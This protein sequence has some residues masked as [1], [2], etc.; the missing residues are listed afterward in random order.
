MKARE[1]FTAGQK[2]QLSAEIRKLVALTNER[3]ERDYDTLI[4]FVLHTV[5]GFGRERL[6]RFFREMA[7]ARRDLKKLFVSLTGSRNL[8]KV[9]L[10]NWTA[11]E[12]SRDIWLTPFFYRK[13]WMAHRESKQLS[14]LFTRC[15]LAKE[16]N[17]E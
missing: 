1:Q 14:L 12:T 3:Y 11:I 6:L 16:R 8:W 15:K 10:D 4:L 5:F 13:N 17:D 2:K 9:W 7:T